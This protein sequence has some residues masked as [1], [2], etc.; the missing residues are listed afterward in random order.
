MTSRTPTLNSTVK[1]C[2]TCKHY[3]VLFKT[4]TGRPQKGKYGQC[5]GVVTLIAPMA[6]RVTFHKQAAWAKND[7]EK[8]PTYA[9]VIDRG[10]E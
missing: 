1:T 10:A 9:A 6:Y 2:G 4:P 5:N 7:A 3:E 8:C